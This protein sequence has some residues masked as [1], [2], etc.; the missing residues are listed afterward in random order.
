[1]A[2]THCGVSNAITFTGSFRT[3]FLVA[4]VWP[5]GIPYGPGREQNIHRR[6]GGSRVRDGQYR[7]WQD[8]SGEAD[9][10][11]W[12]CDRILLQ[13]ELG[14]RTGTEGQAGMSVSW[15]S[16]RWAPPGVY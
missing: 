3:V 1:M 14:L 6:N 11:G 5:D 2:W 4:S 16:A 13:V 7:R 9:V 12:G 15:I 8:H 10:G